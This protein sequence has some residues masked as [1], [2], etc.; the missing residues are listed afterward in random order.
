MDRL[1]SLAR[2]STGFV[3]VALLSLVFGPLM[4]LVYPLRRLRLNLFNVYGKLTGWVVVFLAGVTPRI[5][6]RELLTK[7]R[8]AIYIGNH[9]STLD[10]FVS[11]W[12]SPMGVTGVVKK[13]ISYIPFFGQIYWL[14]GNLLI[15]RKDK[16]GAVEVLKAVVAF[17]RKYH[18]GFWIMPE[19]TRSR[20]GRLQ[21][22]KTGFVHL[23]IDMGLPVV[24]LVF[25]GA[26]KNWE[27]G[28][29]AFKP[30]TLD[31]DVLEPVDTST[32]T[33]ET[34]QEH[35]QAVHDL[36]AAAL[37]EDQKP[38]ARPAV[39][40]ANEALEGLPSLAASNS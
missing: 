3:I 36:Y 37:R 23:A 9:T 8:P 5:H 25:H 4:L 38:L 1:I 40:Q 10:A 21:P 17:V 33:H 27:K 2:L 28:T 6:H 19:G 18:L 14:S 26:Y 11:F 20:D 7:R 30:M 22:F 24:P 12:V 16:E 29:F 34:A 39:A 35:A 32:W 13:E 15:D 31:I